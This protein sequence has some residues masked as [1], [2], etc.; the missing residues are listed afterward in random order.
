MGFRG[1]KGS[2]KGSKQGL[3]RRHVKPLFV[4]PGM[5][6]GNQ[7]PRGASHEKFHAAPSKKQACFLEDA[8]PLRNK[9]RGGLLRTPPFAS[10]KVLCG[11][12]H[13]LPPSAPPSN[14][15]QHPASKPIRY[16][17]SAC[18]TCA[19]FDKWELPN[20]PEQVY[21]M[22]EAFETGL[23]ETQLELVR[24]PASQKSQNPEKIKV[25]EK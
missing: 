23:L 19:P 15:L 4:R 1:T 21:G 12:F 14:T 5:P 18:Q 2:D 10:K 6:I 22:Q 9:G 25:G 8:L 17:E 20:I 24:R 13:G 3:S 16:Q 11:N 7:G